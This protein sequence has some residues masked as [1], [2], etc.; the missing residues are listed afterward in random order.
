[1]NAK[2]CLDSY[3]K[4]IAQEHFEECDMDSEWKQVLQVV[5]VLKAPARLCLEVH[6]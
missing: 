3:V 1:M 4:D 5:E 6:I 2:M